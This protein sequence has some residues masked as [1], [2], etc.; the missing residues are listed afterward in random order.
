MA[1]G[2]TDSFPNPSISTTYAIGYPARI[3]VS[4]LSPNVDIS[5]VGHLSPLMPSW[6]RGL[7]CCECDARSCERYDASTA[8]ASEVLSN[9]LLKT[10][11]ELPESLIV[12][13]LGGSL[14]WGISASCPAE[15]GSL[16]HLYYPRPARNGPFV[17]AMGSWTRPASAGMPEMHHLVLQ[18]WLYC[19][20][21]QL[22]RLILSPSLRCFPK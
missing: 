15:I 5:D 20:I 4:G 11:H 16:S 12:D 18:V 14:G 13:V 7:D 22:R 1:G 3:P 21:G 9:I 17:G 2:A 10:R 8:C 6:R 19:L